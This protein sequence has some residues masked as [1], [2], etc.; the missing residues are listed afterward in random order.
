[1]AK[2]FWEAKKG[3]LTVFKASKEK[4]EVLVKKD[5]IEFS[6]IYSTP[7]FTN[8]RMYLSDRK[9][10]YAIDVSGAAMADSKEAEPAAAE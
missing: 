10:L 5:T 4:A 1:M 7:T 6:S 9:R 3:A 8:G 2:S